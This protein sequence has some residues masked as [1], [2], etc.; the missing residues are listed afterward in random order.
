MRDR[1]G[2]FLQPRRLGEID[3]KAIAPPPVRLGHLG[4]GVA[5]LFLD[6]AFIDLGRGGETRLLSINGFTNI[7]FLR[8]AEKVRFYGAP[9]LPML[10]CSK[11]DTLK[12][13]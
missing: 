6:I 5:G 3:A 12:C 1:G 7:R 11:C 10:F 2:A 13:P 9:Q 8:G 4:A